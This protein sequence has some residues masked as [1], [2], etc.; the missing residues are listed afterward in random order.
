MIAF[1]IILAI[2]ALI[3]ALFMVRCRVAIDYHDTLTVRV[4]LAGFTLWRWPKK[5]KVIPI[6]GR[7]HKKIARLQRKEAA[8]K[9]RR[10]KSKAKKGQKKVKKQAQASST[11]S[12]KKG[13]AENL[14]VIRELLTVVFSRFSHHV[15]L[16]ATRII[17]VVATEDAAKTAILVGA[18]NQ[19]VADI[20]T[21]LDTH[22]KL[23]RLKDARIVVSPDFTAGKTQ[24]DIGISLSLRVWH[25][26][27]ILLRAAWRFVKK[28]KTA[29]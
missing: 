10:E 23:R 27:D 24:A 17:I 11:P 15:K 4:T 1:G 21:I 14:G 28:K 9:M 20:L 19:A 13:L 26:A 8:K 18:V 25:M 12:T 5:E 29:D 6:N 7:T 2:A 22:G 3:F 16:E